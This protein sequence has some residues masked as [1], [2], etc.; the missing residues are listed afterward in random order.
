MNQEPLFNID[1]VVTVPQKY[2]WDN[3]VPLLQDTELDYNNPN[4]GIGGYSPFT[5]VTIFTQI[6]AHPKSVALKKTVDFGG[7]YNHHNNVIVSSL[8]GSEKFCH[9]YVMPGTYTVKMTVEDYIKLDFDATPYLYRQPTSILKQ[10]L[11]IFWQ[12]CNFSCNPTDN[13][14]NQ[15][16]TWNNTSNA[17]KLE[18]QERE[19]CS[20][21]SEYNTNQLLRWINVQGPCIKQPYKETS[22]KWENQ[23][24]EV[25]LL[26]SPE[27]TDAFSWK[28]LQCA[29]CDNR[30]WSET[31]SATCYERPA[32]LSAIKIEYV[33]T[34]IVKVNELLPQAYLQV[35]QSQNFDDRVSPY[36]VRLSPRFSQT[37]SFPIEQIDWDLGDGSPILTQKRW[38]INRSDDFVFNNNFPFDWQD[39][40]NYDVV[41]T[42]SKTKESSFTFYPSLTVYASSTKSSNCASGVVGPLKVEEIPEE[43][44]YED[45]FIDIQNKSLSFQKIKLMQ[46]ELTEHG[47][48]LIGEVDGVAVAW[49]Y[50]K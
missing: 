34:K 36:T 27:L 45:T 39:P 9:V 50:D 31:T 11:P 5:F 8:T 3:G 44:I 46:N 7:Y 29:S 4:N 6:T 2:K 21:L 42:Y 23:T 43:E 22:W 24:C 10:Q 16:I 41:H 14:R 1:S 37:G 47:K 12:W 25:P 18:Q 48:L 28:E 17:Q 13:L 15:S 19:I 40:R 38:D 33:R 49:R 20:E 30:T 35:E 26:T 32:N